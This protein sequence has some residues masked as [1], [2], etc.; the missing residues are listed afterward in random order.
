MDSHPNQSP[1]ENLP[2]G[3]W[4]RIAGD[5]FTAN[6]WIYWPDFILCALIGWGG[7]ALVEM[8]PD[9]SLL[10]IFFFV[11][12]GLALYRG[13]LFIHE[14]SH[15]N[16]ADL[17]G[18]SIAWNLIIGIPVLFPSFMYRGVHTEHHRR[19]T[20]GTKEDGEYIPFGASPF[21]K[22][23]FYILQ[24]FILPVSVL[25]RFAVITPISFLHPKLRRFV[26]LQLSAL[27]IQFSA[28]RNIPTGIDYRNWHVQEILCCLHSWLLIFLF[29]NGVIDTHFVVHVYLMMAFLFTINAVRTVVAHR[30]RNLNGEMSFA[31]QLLDSVNVVGHPLLT[32][33]WAPVGLRF[34]GLHHVF[35]TI[36]Y[37]SLGLAHKR[38]MAALPEDSLYRRTVEPSLFS[39]LRTLWR[40]TQHRSQP[41]TPTPTTT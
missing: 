11:A 35:P 15:R 2:L 14:I 31:D 25:I 16:R 36:P 29:V 8:L 20:Y 19:Q 22:S 26:M 27:A 30:Y 39:A 3:E 40:N 28:Q 32:E 38:L 37:H 1:R 5:V 13:T 23:I 17:P 7:F 9:F 34:H 6:P 41:V 4:K 33:A 10:Q 12:S 24:S 21:L 18:F